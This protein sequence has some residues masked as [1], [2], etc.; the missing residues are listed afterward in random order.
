M[1][2]TLQGVRVLVVE[3]DPELRSLTELILE[4]EGVIVRSASLGSDALLQLDGF[5]PHV[6]LLDARLPD[7]T[8]PELG[9]RIAARYPGCSQVLV[10]GDAEGVQ[11]WRR[12]GRLALPKP[13]EIDELLD[14]V[15]RAAARP[16]A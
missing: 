7:V 4:E 5:D 16:A 9:E 8:G 15:R 6:A 2:I 13:F 10:S 3:D 1:S 11:D 14:L 12:S